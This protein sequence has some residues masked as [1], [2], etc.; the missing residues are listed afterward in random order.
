MLPTHM[1]GEGAMPGLCSL[2]HR[3]RGAHWECPAC[4]AVY[5]KELSH[6]NIGRLELIKCKMA[7]CKSF[8]YGAKPPRM[9]ILSC[10]DASTFREPSP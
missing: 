4:S 5:E 3:R 2:I 10:G 1:D 7:A 8:R 6:Q 9:Q